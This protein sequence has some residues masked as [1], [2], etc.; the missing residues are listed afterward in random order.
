LESLQLCSGDW[1]L[2][3]DSNLVLSNAL[4]NEI[5]KNMKNRSK[6]V[7]AVK[8]LNL[9]GDY[10]H[11]FENRAFMA[12]H[13]IFVKRDEV[14]W[15]TNV[16]RPVFLGKTISYKYW[17]VN[18]SRVRPAWRYWLR[19]EQFDRRYYDNIARKSNDGHKNIANIQ[20]H[21]QKEDK[22][23]SILEYVENTKGLTLEDIKELAPEWFLGLLVVESKRL[24]PAHKL[25]LPAVILEER[26][27]PRYRLICEDGKIVGRWPEL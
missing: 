14:K 2:M 15:D 8:S 12:Y 13:R 21:W 5:K 18:L 4:K 27:N 3:Q 6:F 1:V 19:G 7:G 26:M 17:A 11:F 25:G 23:H 16:D 10:N 22:Y 24:T 20:Y 9:M